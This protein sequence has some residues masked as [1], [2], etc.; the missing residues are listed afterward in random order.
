MPGTNAVRRVSYDAIDMF[1]V[2]SVLVST[3]DPV[4]HTNF[5]SDL[6]IIIY[7]DLLF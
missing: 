6:F 5:Y 3:A 1:G 7:A 2:D 4:I